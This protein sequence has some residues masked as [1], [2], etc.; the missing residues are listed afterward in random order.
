M[1]LSIESFWRVFQEVPPYLA[2]S[3]S[4]ANCSTRRTLVN[5][6]TSYLSEQELPLPCELLRISRYSPQ[7]AEMTAGRSVAGLDQLAP[8][9]VN[10]VSPLFRTS[11]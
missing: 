5:P 3:R 8:L 1:N 9:A 11:Y 7:M 10:R 4:Q 6:F 2:S